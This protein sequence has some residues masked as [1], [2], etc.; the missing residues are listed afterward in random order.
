MTVPP[1]LRHRYRYRCR[2]RQLQRQ[3]FH[4][5]VST[6]PL[7]LAIAIACLI[8]I[9]PC[10]ALADAALGTGGPK[11]SGLAETTVRA[12]LSADLSPAAD[13]EQ[14]AN[15]RFTSPV[16]DAGTF[17]AAANLFAVAGTERA[18]TTDA[19]LERLYVAFKTERFD[20]DAGLM[21]IPFGYGQAFRPTDILNAA[22]PLY[23]NARLSG[24]LGGIVSW[25]L[26]EETRI[27]AFAS[28]RVAADA[29]D[30]F[31]ITDPLADPG[32]RPLGGLMFETHSPRYSAQALLAARAPD[33]SSSSPEFRA[34]VSLKIEALVGIVADAL[35]FTDGS[36]FPAAHGARSWVKAAIGADYSFF[37]GSLYALAQY[38]Y[39]GAGVLS[40][41]D[42]LSDLYGT[43]AWADL[44][45]ASRVPAGGFSDYYRRQY[46]YARAL[47]KASDYTRVGVSALVSLED[48]S[49]APMIDFEHDLTRGV[50]LSAEGRAYLD[51]RDLA[52]R[53][54][55]ELGSAN[56]G[57]AGSLSGKAT[58]RF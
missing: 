2:Q 7:A 22:N 57:L 8:A 38:F 53:W 50:T 27:A 56:V 44:P 31:D 47:W 9:T 45:L 30:S 40:S 28:D 54:P 21:R 33:S 55:G 20:I 18:L 49:F 43:D 58:V 42:S 16:G 3:R 35:F 23:P 34:G 52:G 37:D 51:A 4:H 14:F 32:S 29:F 39:N 25:Y 1:D 46:L 36:G 12:D 26:G 5:A 6:S 10:P 48:G 24:V 13:V 11:F 19:E 17:N 15:L 41:S